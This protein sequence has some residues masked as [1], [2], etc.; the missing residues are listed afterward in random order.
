MELIS[1]ILII[2][3]RFIVK[4]FITIF[5]WTMVIFF[6]NIPEEKNKK[7]L[8]IAL[9]SM[10]W[11]ILIIG[12]S[13]PAIT[14]AF[15]NYIPFKD[16]K[17]KIAFFMETA[18]VILIPIAV[19]QIALLIKGKEK[20]KIWDYV[21]F[22]MK[23]YYYS[24]VMGIAMIVMFI[25]SPLIRLKRFVK[26]EETVSMP[27]VIVKG[28]LEEVLKLLQEGLALNDTLTVAERSGIFFRIP[29]FLLRRIFWDVLNV[30]TRNNKVLK[31]EK[32]RIFFNATDIMI[33]GEKKKIEK[34]KEI[35]VNILIYDKTFMTWS[36]KGNHLEKEALDVYAAY[37]EKKKGEEETI[38]MLEELIQICEKSA[39]DYCEWDII[40][41]K[42]YIYENNILKCMK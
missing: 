18:G 10:I 11:I 16:L 33:E 15:Y 2:A 34:V 13:H 31:G 28:R 9:L 7:I 40:T 3:A 26:R 12:I 42:L 41:R 6:G 39:L 27:A 35:L 24:F 19:G 20:N 5:G 17:D 38:E 30:D 1:A 37:L 14:N 36:D 22:G 21:L 8:M 29:N 4:I 25:A 32:F 23:G